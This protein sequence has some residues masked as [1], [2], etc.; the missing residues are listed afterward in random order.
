VAKLCAQA[1]SD[2]VSSPSAESSEVDTM[3]FRDVY[4]PFLCVIS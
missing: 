4:M 3:L 1:S 2:Y